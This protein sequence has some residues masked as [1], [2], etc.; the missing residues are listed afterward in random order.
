MKPPETNLRDDETLDTFYRGRIRVFQKK[1]GYRFSVDAPLLAD[2][3]RTG[4]RDEILELGTGCGIIPL[5]LSFKPFRRI[6]ALEIQPALADLSR[7]NVALNGLGDRITILEEDWRTFR[8]ARKYDVVLSNPPY[9]RGGTGF[10]SRTAE[11]NVAKHE[12]HGDIED[13]MA[14]TTELL[15][16]R[17]RAFFVFPER[18][19][20]DFIEAAGGRGLGPRRLRSVLPREDEPANL[21]LTEM[22]LS[23]APETEEILPPLILFGADGRYT[24][25]AELIFAGPAG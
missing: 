16:P 4:P 5:L 2:F 13:V 10:P 3:V 20:G 14:A 9:V 21:F 18:R 12:V 11:K 7:R 22:V 17:G 15:A 19:R 23:A 25:E 6:T 24:A 1:K 8:P